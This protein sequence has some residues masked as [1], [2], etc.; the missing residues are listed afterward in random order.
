MIAKN[1]QLETE[2]EEQQAQ[3]RNSPTQQPQALPPETERVKEFLQQTVG[4]VTKE[5]LA[6]SMQSIQDRMALN[7]QH[8]ELQRR[9]SGEDGRPA[10]NYQEIENFMR[11]RGIYDPEAAYEIMHKDE[12]FDWQLKQHEKKRGTSQS[13]GIKPR[14]GGTVPTDNTI[15]REKVQEWL[16]TP[17]GRKK[18]EQN[19]GKI[20]QLF[21]EGKL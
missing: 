4:V 16:K 20:L 12:L 11:K 2:L 5:E 19:R 15:T 8:T 6:Q 3:L 21:Q 14:S 10:Y 17:E 7:S 13:P 18:Y 1:K 9:Y